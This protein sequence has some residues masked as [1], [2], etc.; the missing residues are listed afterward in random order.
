MVAAVCVCVCVVHTSVVQYEILSNFVDF[1][2]LEQHGKS[3]KNQN[4]KKDEVILRR[5]DCLISNSIEI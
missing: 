2:D 3:K 5:T 4:Q 1:D